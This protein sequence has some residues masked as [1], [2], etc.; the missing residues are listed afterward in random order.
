MNN[1]G[2]AYRL[3]AELPTVARGSWRSCWRPSGAIRGPV[4]TWESTRSSS[5]LYRASGGLGSCLR[6]LNPQVAKQP[7]ERLLVGV[8]LLPAASTGRF[9]AGCMD[10]M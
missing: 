5:A 8:V 1:P 9:L 6:L 10:M 3:A 7:V 2:C 4:G